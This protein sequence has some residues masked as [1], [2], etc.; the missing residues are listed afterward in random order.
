M[1]KYIESIMML[2]VGMFVVTACSSSNDD[3]DWQSGAANLG[4]QVYFSSELPAVVSTPV[5]AS[6]FTIKVNRVKTDA[7]QTVPLTI[8]LPEGCIY[9]PAAN[10][11]TFAQ[12]SKTADVVFNYDP[13]KVEYGKYYDITMAIADA[14]FTT[15]YGSSQFAFKAGVTEWKKMAGKATF[16]DDLIG[17]SL[18]GVMKS[19]AVDIQES[20][21]TPGRYRLVAPYGPN[22]NFPSIVFS[23]GWL[24]DASSVDD[25]KA[26]YKD[27]DENTYMVINAQD[28]KAVWIET[29]ESGYTNLGG[30]G[31]A[32]GVTSWVDY[33]VNVQGKYTLEEYKAKYPEDFGVLED[34]VISFPTGKELLITA[35]GALGWYANTS[36]LFAIALPGSS[37]KDL[38]AA[39]VYQGIFTN[40]EGA[41][42]ANC[43]L[44]LGADA[45]NVKA[46]VM[47]QDVDDQ[48]VADAI[49]DGSLEALDVKAGN[50]SVPIPA[51]MTGAL[52]VIV[53]VI[54]NGTAKTVTSVNFE[55]YGGG[56]NPWTSLGT[57]YFTDDVITSI[58][59]SETGEPATI[60]VEVLENTEN[61]GIYRLKNLF[62]P[63][64]PAFN[65]IGG[66]GDGK[67]DIE[68]N[69]KDKDGVYIL[70]QYIGLDHPSAG[71][72]SLETRAGY[73]VS[74]Y[75]FDAVKSSQPGFFGKLA[76]G[77]ITFPYF[78]KVDEEGNPVEPEEIYQ[79]YLNMPSGNY[80]Y[81]GE[82]AAMK[83]VLPTASASVKAMAKKRAKATEFAI[84]LNAFKTLP[85]MKSKARHNLKAN[86][87]FKKVKTLK[88]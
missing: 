57:G 12:G 7:E 28:P 53:A 29:F 39:L 69:A 70:D 66:K 44:T 79:G 62:A 50:I 48:A 36:S 6:S 76:N 18:F 83:L 22:T 46:I 71:A 37:L 58:F 23:N 82:N 56:K 47:E 15:P 54:D 25:V 43:E 9:T 38:A 4:E 33:T 34:G 77:E 32:M 84:R 5:D 64:A 80:F 14:N 16:R 55:Y 24:A 72:F 85:I 61:P 10:Q 87:E 63:L 17:G 30:S 52:K 27:T 68:I 49:A 42:F 2:L 20:V 1:K 73:F 67:A 3:Y 45:T 78:V 19:W 51:D 86:L 60:E 74:V 13:T 88:R 11:V 21:A 26:A 59:L 31:V 75:G 81:I 35:D 65:E 40:P 8:T 41:V